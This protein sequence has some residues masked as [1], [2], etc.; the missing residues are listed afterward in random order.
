[1]F[2]GLLTDCIIHFRE[3]IILNASLFVSALAGIYAFK[4]TGKNTDERIKAL[5][6]LSCV[7]LLL[8]IFP[9]SASVIRIVFGTYYDV[10]D[11]WGIIP[12]IPVGAV[13]FSAM[14]GEAY[15]AFSSEKKSTVTLGCA[16]L[17]SAVLLC[18]SLGTP[19]ENADGR[20][21]HASAGEKEV[22]AYVAD[23]FG[24]GEASVLL[25]ANDD[26]TASIHALSADVRT[27]YGRDMWDG[28]LTKNRYGTY[29]EEIRTLR[30]DL[31]NMEDN[32]FYL[33]AEVAKEAFSMGADIVVVPGSCDPSSF[34]AEGLEYEA[35]TAGDGEMFY[36]VYGGIL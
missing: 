27:L 4:K 26:I 20:Y 6:I 15:K 30:D 8:V 9:V 16:L 32:K 25:V 11:I 35:F 33:A 14:A 12:L 18:G 19:T 1:M 31:L 13:C 17:A 22:A 10:P 7:S 24:N 29:S 36:L 34:E 28:R 23:K 5:S 21:E 2:K 3:C